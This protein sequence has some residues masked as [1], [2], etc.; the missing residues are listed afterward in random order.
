MY[1]KSKDIAEKKERQTAAF[2]LHG[3]PVP[4][5]QGPV[6]RWSGH[7]GKWT[8]RQLHK[9]RRRALKQRPRKSLLHWESECNWKGW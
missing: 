5:Y 1:R 4:E 7:S 6:G 9:A 2:I 8:K 3:R